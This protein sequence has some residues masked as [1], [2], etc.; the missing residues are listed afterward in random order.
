V[1]TLWK[2]SAREQDM[3]YCRLPRYSDFSDQI[4]VKKTG[5]RFI[6]SLFKVIAGL[7]FKKQLLPVLITQSCRFCSFLC[8]HL[9]NYFDSDKKLNFENNEPLNIKNRI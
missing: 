6:G 7:I 5:C 4:S 1:H 3:E 8:S 2:I 9:T